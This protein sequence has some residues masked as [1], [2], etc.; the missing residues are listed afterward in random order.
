MNKNF[1]F[2]WSSKTGIMIH[3]LAWISI[4]VLVPLIRIRNIALRVG[5]SVFS[6]F[7]QICYLILHL[8][9]SGSRSTQRCESVYCDHLWGATPSLS[10]PV[11]KVIRTSSLCLVDAPTRYH[12][13][14]PLPTVFTTSFVLE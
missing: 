14:P 9:V 11:E 6:V 1:K 2:F 5:A 8:L 13:V 3:H 7:L 10:T 12:V 4:R